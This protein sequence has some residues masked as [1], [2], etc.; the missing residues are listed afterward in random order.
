MTY[1]REAVI[2]THELLDSL[3]KAENKVQT[4][5]KIGLSTSLLPFFLLLNSS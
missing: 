3:V 1:Y 5:V 2:H 4:R